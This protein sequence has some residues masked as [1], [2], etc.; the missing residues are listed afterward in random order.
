M[1]G[2]DW[3]LDQKTEETPQDTDLALMVR[4]INTFKTTFKKI[5]EFIIGTEDMGTTATDVTGAVK[6]IN[7]KV[8]KLQN[9]VTCSYGIS[10]E[11]NIT[12]SDSSAIYS[13]IPWDKKIIDSDSFIDQTDNTKIVIPEEGFY[14][15]QCSVTWQ[16]HSDGTRILRLTKNST[17]II[18]Y[19]SSKSADFAAT[20]QNISILHY[21]NANETLVVSA[22][23]NCTEDLK[24]MLDNSNCNPRLNIYKLG[25][26]V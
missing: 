2:T 22:C 15:V 19:D 1:A 14:L 18:A 17:D 26:K 20:R 24:L 6:E 12:K 23:H 13:D 5:K 21:F 16:G 8:A 10:A 4:G 3:R 25:D 9:I 7:D 11:F